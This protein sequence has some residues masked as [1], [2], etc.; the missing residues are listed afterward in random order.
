MKVGF[1]VFGD[2][3]IDVFSDVV[4]DGM[5]I[6]PITPLFAPTDESRDSVQSRKIVYFSVSNRGRHRLLR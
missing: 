1:E 5:K 4:I 6:V 2:E 3:A